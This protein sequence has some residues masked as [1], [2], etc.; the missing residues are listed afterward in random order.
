M[1][2]KAVED[3]GAGEAPTELGDEEVQPVAGTEDVLKA[4]DV[5][6]SADTKVEI[7]GSSNGETPLEQRLAAIFDIVSPKKS[8]M[9]PKT[10]LLPAKDAP[11]GAP[12]T[13]EA[14]LFGTLIDRLEVLLSTD[15]DV[16]KLVVEQALRRHE[17]RQR[18]HS[19]LQS[20]ALAKAKAW[21][22]KS[23]GKIVTASG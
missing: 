13:E 3:V 21:K 17:V 18:G 19:L 15:A 14:E 5:T 16:Y 23:S 10:V 22:Q 12:P 9:F 11:K 8:S 4:S 2:R 7:S 1:T 20:N 6:F